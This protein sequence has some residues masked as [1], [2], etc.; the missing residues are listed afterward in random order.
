MKRNAF[1]I[2]LRLVEP[3]IFVGVGAPPSDVGARMLSTPLYLVLTSTPMYTDESILFELHYHIV[4]T[5]A[6]ADL[7]NAMT[8]YDLC[9]DP[10]NNDPVVL[11]QQLKTKIDELHDD[12]VRRAKQESIRQLL[13]TLQKEYNTN[14][15]P[16][17]RQLQNKK[18]SS[19]L[20]ISMLLTGDLHRGDYTYEANK[21]LYR[22]L[23]EKEGGV[24]ILAN[25]VS[26]ED[27]DKDL[28]IKDPKGL[29]IQYAVEILKEYFPAN[30]RE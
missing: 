12:E 18:W 8:Y 7:K 21:R 10:R 5:K 2:I 29:A 14:Q 4:S 19:G 3:Y 16:L 22:N 28:K 24:S 15:Y 26:D 17:S 20:D 13:E 25:M 6:I 11:V 27:S 30:S 9:S 23:F 1:E